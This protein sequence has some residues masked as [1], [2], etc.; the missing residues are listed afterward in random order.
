M[1]NRLKWISAGRGER[2]GRMLLR[3]LCALA[4]SVLLSACGSG[5]HENIDQGMALV[6][7]LDYEAALPYFDA[8]LVNKEDVQLALRGQALAYIGLSQYDKAVESLERAL[9]YSDARLDQI[10]FDMNYYLATAYYKQGDLEKAGQVYEAIVALR[11]KEETAW[12][13]KGVVELEQGAVEAAKADF[14]RAVELSPRDYDLRINIFCSCADNG[15][16][17][18]G[19]T[20]LQA[21]L[22]SDDKKLTE[23]NR[24][25]MYFYLEDYNNARN[26][27]EKA[28]D[29]AGNVEV[30]SMLGQ[31][32]EQLGDYNYAASVYSNYLSTTPDAR[33][34]NLLGLC[35]L[36]SGDYASALNAFQ[37]G[38][39]MEGNEIMQ[40]LRYNEIV[41][42]EHLGDFRQATVLMQNYLSMYPDDAK[43]QR[44]YEFL[45]T[46]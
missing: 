2:R 21:V 7:Q 44:E 4:V 42:Y 13:L 6:E 22:D 29:G 36:R 39:A 15:Q 43:A 1:R 17:D 26:S 38:I 27:L 20:Y 10:D 23:Y 33:I 12:Y 41:A 19:S 25:R 14:D 34:Y 45:Q 16:R 9:T 28:R 32:Y 5:G 31:T 8:A 35:Q 46:R 11:P 24:G 3:P 40:A 37:A 18:L 30:I